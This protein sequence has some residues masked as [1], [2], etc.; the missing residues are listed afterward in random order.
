LFLFSIGL[1]PSVFVPFNFEN[2]RNGSFYR[3]SILKTLK[4]VHFARFC[5]SLELKSFISA[6]SNFRWSFPVSVQRFSIA[7]LHKK[8]H[9]SFKNAV[10]LALFQ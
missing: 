7:K 10:I 2:A 6:V 5:Y 3:H 9:I 4:M 1:K 8:L